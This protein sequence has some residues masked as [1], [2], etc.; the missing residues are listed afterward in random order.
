MKVFK[1]LLII[2]I[3]S[4]ISFL[5]IKKVSNGHLNI[6][7]NEIVFN[8]KIADSPLEWRKGL[9]GLVSLE[10]KEGMLF[11]F[12]N[13]EKRNFHMK[14]MNF[15]LDLLLIKDKIIIGLEKNMIIDQGEKKYN[16]PEAIDM[17]LELKA[18]SIIK[19]NININNIIKI[20]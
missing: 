1:I 2:I 14:D 3:V 12:P 8:V 7:I 17:V 11:I 19:Y 4:I 9:G 16:S 10:E 13:L 6:E 15:A 20:N 18:G 5:L